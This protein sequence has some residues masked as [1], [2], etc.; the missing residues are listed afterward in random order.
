MSTYE[1]SSKNPNFIEGNWNFSF[2]RDLFQGEKCVSD[3]STVFQSDVEKSVKNI[4]ISNVNKLIFGHVNI[5]SLR[6]KF[7]ILSE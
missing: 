4:R 2:E 5:N 6:N 7:D 1:F 3:D